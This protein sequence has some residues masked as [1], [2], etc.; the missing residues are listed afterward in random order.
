MAETL[1]QESGPSEGVEPAHAHTAVACPVCFTELQEDR[2]WW[3]ARPVGARLVGLVVARD[4][5]PS[6]VQQR[7]DLTRFGV[8][9]EGFR[10]PAPETL[11]S[12]ERR[13]TRLFETLKPGDVLVVTS[14]RALGRD[15]DE[16]TR[17]ITALSR[18][19][20]VVKVLSHGAPHLR[21]PAD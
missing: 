3:R 14:V 15:I 4:D 8:P 10:H 21:A 18:R 2:N 19:G 11:E 13:L 9:I 5:M 17:T 1:S 6:V 16:G 12:W 20:V 7:E